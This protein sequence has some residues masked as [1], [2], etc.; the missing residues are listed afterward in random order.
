VK[1]NDIVLPNAVIPTFE[2]ILARAQRETARGEHAFR[3]SIA[4]AEE[5]VNIRP[6]S[7]VPREDAEIG[8][9]YRWMSERFSVDLNVSG[10]DNP[11]DGDEVRA[12]GT[13]VAVELGNWSLAASTMDRWWGPGW[14]G[15]L[16]LS[17][18]AR[19]IPSI[20]FGRNQTR[21][22]ESKWLRWI[23]PWDLDVIWGQLEKDRAVPNARLFG[24]RMNF[25]PTRGLEIGLSRTA[26]WCGEGR[27]CGFDTF[28]DMLFGRDNVGDAG[29]TPENEPGNQ[30]A[31]FDARWTNRWFGAPVSLYGQMIGEDEAG[32]FPSLYLF[33]AGVEGSVITRGQNSLRW[34]V[35]FAGTSCGFLNEDRPNCAYRNRLYPSGYT[36]S[37]R[38]IGHS[39][40]N[41]ARVVSA[42][43]ILVSRAGDLWQ[44][45]GRA[46]DLNRVGADANHSVAV[47]PQDL[48]SLDLQHSRITSIGRF[49]I[50]IGYEQ[51]EIMA[52]GDSTSDVR[53]FVRWT[54][55]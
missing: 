53:G 55:R 36:Y 13:R 33:Q 24:M 34:F 5:P 7:N 3:A 40:D 6:F 11:A 9:G 21:A 2:R 43:L 50:G 45:I 35:E 28:I 19:P 38:I 20:T 4:V 26:Q 1:A 47:V 18:N 37:K 54:S 31:G 51:R 25:R 49:D 17:N 10:I 41:D 30:L 23:G 44:A 32:G 12:D 39:L 29:I 15:S 27:P 8:A 48:L 14:D 46:G 42:S 16:I 52:T 22:F